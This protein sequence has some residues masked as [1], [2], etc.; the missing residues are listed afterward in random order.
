MIL[1]FYSVLS[2]GGGVREKK[3]PQFVLQLN[4]SLRKTH[5][6]TEG[7]AYIR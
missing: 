4:S 1:A 6:N 2:G 3:I 7:Q 5:V